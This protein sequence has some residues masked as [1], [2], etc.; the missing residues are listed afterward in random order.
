MMNIN[1]NRREKLAVYG[2]GLVVVIFIVSQLII[3]P[4]FEKRDALHEKLTAKR[5]TLSEMRQLERDYQD[6][7]S[8]ITASMSQFEQ[9][10]NNF[11]LFSFLDQLAGETGIKKHVSYMK[12]STTINEKTGVGLSRVEMELRGISLKDLTR[13]L[14][15]VE[16]SENMVIVKRLSISRKGGEKAMIDAVM[17]VE[18]VEI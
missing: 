18:T 13:Y 16:T 9:R 15:E 2:G 8:D 17:Q 1:L 3:T 11:T 14:Y 5:R 4:L 10:P 7:Q 12:P 6:L